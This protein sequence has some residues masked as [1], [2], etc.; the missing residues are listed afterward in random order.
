MGVFE[1]RLRGNASPDQTRATECALFL[2][3]GD[4]LPKLRGAD[5]GDIS[6]GARADHHDIERFRHN[7]VGSHLLR[8]LALHNLAS[9]LNE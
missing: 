7:G 9:V 4:R 2:D 6:A 8:T 1:K 5:G 3:D